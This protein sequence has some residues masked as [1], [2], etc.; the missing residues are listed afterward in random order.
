[1]DNTILEKDIKNNAQKIEKDKNLV[2]ELEL[3][4]ASLILRKRK[5]S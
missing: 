1:M 3:K 2:P 5:H 4:N